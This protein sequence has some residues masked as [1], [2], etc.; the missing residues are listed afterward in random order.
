VTLL[1]VASPMVP[2]LIASVKRRRIGRALV[3]VAGL[4]LA[5]V[6][7]AMALAP[8][9]PVASLMRLDQAEITMITVS[10]WLPFYAATAGFV[11]RLGLA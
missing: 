10:W 3:I 8:A 6:A 9:G 4:A 7:L 5:G 11:R 1:V 2:V